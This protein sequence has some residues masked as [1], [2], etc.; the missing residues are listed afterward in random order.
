M[1]INVWFFAPLLLSLSLSGCTRRSEDSPLPV[2]DSATD[3][4]NDSPDD[5]AKPPLDPAVPARFLPEGQTNLLMATRVTVDTAR[6]RAFATSLVSGA[7]AVIDIDAAALLGVYDVGGQP[8]LPEAAMDGRG[9]VWISGQRVLSRLNPETGQ[10][11]GFDLGLGRIE[12][13]VT[14][15]GDGGAVVMGDDAARV[16]WIVRVDAN[17]AELARAQLEGSGSCIGIADDGAAVVVSEI[18]DAGGTEVE[19]Y[20]IDGLALLRSCPA[21]A[22][23]NTVTQA[24]DGRF[25]LPNQDFVGEARCDGVAPEKLTIGQENKQALVVPGAPAGADVLV[26]DRIGDS[27]LRGPNWGI[28]RWLDASLVP[29]GA[30]FSTGKNSGHGGMDGET[31]YIWMNS[32]GTSE[33]QAYDPQTG[34]LVQRVQLGV[35]L[36]SV[37]IADDSPGIV[38]VTGRLSRTLGRADLTT[39][40]VLKTTP[41]DGWPVQPTI[42]GQTLFVLDGLTQE[43]WAFDRDSLDVL[44]HYDLGLDDNIGLVFDDLAYDEARGV[45]LVADAQANALVAVDPSSGA[46]I[47]RWALAGNPADD[48]DTIGVQ[49]VV[50]VGDAYVVLNTVEGRLTR[51]EAGQSEIALSVLLPVSVTRELGYAAVPDPLWTDGERLYVGGHAID[52]LTFQELPDGKRA[53]TQVLGARGG[54]LVGWDATAEDVVELDPA[55]EVVSRVP[56]ATSTILPGIPLW[57]AAWGE[58]LIYVH[59]DDASVLTAELPPSGRAR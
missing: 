36:E 38:W 48:P 19:V 23:G 53:L 50:V 27:T 34:M 52:P 28:A 55:G 49:R 31:G 44:A 47:Q 9:S 43:L 18:L 45:L 51:I 57:D 35:D 15:A 26:L 3:S 29:T 4:V 11:D 1:V 14:L 58:R 5:T 13:I 7:V 37:A 21:S 30:T 10:L 8:S 17:G 39:G 20:S 24:L 46:T 22:A 54:D 25:L 56:I 16:S 32:E 40:E 42:V 2:D 59:N 6:R 33:A 12:G 41:F